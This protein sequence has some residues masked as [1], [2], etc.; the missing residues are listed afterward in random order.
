MDYTVLN[1]TTKKAQ[2]Y[3]TSYK[4]AIKLGHKSVNKFYKNCS[5]DKRAAEQYI[6]QR[7][8][9]I[10]AG[11]YRIIGGN[12]FNFTCG[13]TDDCGNIHI[14]TKCNHYIILE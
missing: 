10:T 8:M 14:I 1:A 12:S 11:M 5:D 13:Y 2:Y 4:R 6:K 3:K 7:I 9:P